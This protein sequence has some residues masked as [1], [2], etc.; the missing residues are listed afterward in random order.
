[1]LA[2]LDCK[3]I[4]S[5]CLRSGDEVL[6]IRRKPLLQD[7]ILTEQEATEISKK[8]KETVFNFEEDFQEKWI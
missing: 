2:K 5:S 3:I 6:Q 1:M 7:S 8:E 4:S